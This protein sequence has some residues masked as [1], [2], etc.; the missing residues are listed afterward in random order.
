MLIQFLIEKKFLSLC[1]EKHREKYFLSFF[2]L[3]IQKCKFCIRI[4]NFFNV[5]SYQFTYNSTR[6]ITSNPLK[7]I[8]S[9]NNQRNVKGLNVFY[10]VSLSYAYKDSSIC[11]DVLFLGKFRYKK[12]CFFRPQFLSIN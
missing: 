9:K 7:K 10:Y 12:T 6:K 5:Q 3:F 8:K 11:M 2:E 1:G 4:G